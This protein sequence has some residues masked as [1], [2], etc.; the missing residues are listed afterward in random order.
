MKSLLLSTAMM[1]ALPSVTSA[2]SDELL[3]L[4]SEYANMPQIVQMMDDMFAP[5]SMAAQFIGSLPA[6]VKVSDEQAQQIGGLLSGVMVDIRP[7]MQELMIQ[8]SAEIFSA[9]EIRALIAF[10]SSEHGASVMSKMQPLMQRV[11]GALNPV[12]QQKMQSVQPEI[13]KIMQGN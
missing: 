3:S 12:L 6:N 9:D 4:A 1:L 11:M 7:R 8:T 13:I 2:Q 5:D 10:Y